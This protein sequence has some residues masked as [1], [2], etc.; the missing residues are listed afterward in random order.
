MPPKAVMRFTI[1]AKVGLKHTMKLTILPRTTMVLFPGHLISINISSQPI[2]NALGKEICEEYQKNI[3]LLEQ[4]LVYKTLQQRPTLDECNGFITSPE[5]YK[6]M[7]S[8]F[9]IC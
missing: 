8:H 2:W 5:D 1:S 3:A 6:K 7:S 4:G 9:R